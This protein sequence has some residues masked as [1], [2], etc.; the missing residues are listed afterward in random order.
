MKYHSENSKILIQTTSGQ[1]PSPPLNHPHL[2]KAERK[3]ASE[4]PALPTLPLS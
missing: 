4:S 3:R 1:T 2:S